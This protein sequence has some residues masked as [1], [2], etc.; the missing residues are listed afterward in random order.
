MVMLTSVEG[1]RVGHWTNHD[2]KAG[3]TVV[4]LPEGTVASGEVRGGAPATR[5]FELL[6][7]ERF[8]PRIDARN[9]SRLGLAHS[10]GRTAT[11]SSAD[12]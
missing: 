2:A 8:V 1:V 7:P 5:E 4:L 10:S 12:E 6:K 11:M 3:C 9:S